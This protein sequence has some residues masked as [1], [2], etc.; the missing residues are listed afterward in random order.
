MP[1]RTKMVNRAVDMRSFAEGFSFPGIDPRQWISYGVVEQPIVEFDDDFGPMITVRLLPSDTQ[2]VCRI[3]CQIAGNKE[4]EYY[5]FVE[6][7][8]VLVAI[9]DGN[10]RGGCVIIARLNNSIDK[11]PGDSVA[12]Q[13]PTTN[14]FAFRRQRTP[15]IHEISG[16]YLLHQATTEALLSFDTKGSIT[17]K[18]GTKNAIQMTPDVVGF[19][20]GDAKYLLQFDLT[21]GRF[22]LQVDD[23]IVTLS[24]SSASPSVNTVSV[25]GALAIGTASNPS[26]EHVAT[27]E[28]VANMMLAF[29]TI[30]AAACA[31]A[32]ATIGSVPVVG[33]PV[34][35][36][37]ATLA[38]AFSPPS[39]AAAIAAASQGTIAGPI[40]AAVST[41]FSGSL[42][43]PP[44]VPGMGQVKPGLGATGTLTG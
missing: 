43:K 36:A 24:S 17:I 44:G 23:C 5:P 26:I 13:D 40:A 28:S 7:D 12:G 6:N 20:S 39:L 22:T 11:F 16:P 27:A 19:Q 25:P 32:G 41:A 42:Q 3:G 34:A 38:V 15:F 1:R 9:P 37:L 10:E 2:T 30:V 33:T 8:E 4:G 18:D 35:A 31:A 21:G 29:N 14:T